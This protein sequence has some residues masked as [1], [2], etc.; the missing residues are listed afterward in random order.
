MENLIPIGCIEVD[1]TPV[2]FSTRGQARNIVSCPVSTPIS[3][4]VTETTFV[5][6]PGPFGCVIRQP[7]TQTVNVDCVAT[8]NMPPTLVPI[9]QLICPPVAAAAATRPCGCQ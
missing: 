3:V 6:T 9:P 2:S 8:V 5:E 1:C 4:P 7:V